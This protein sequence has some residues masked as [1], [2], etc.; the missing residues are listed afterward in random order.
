MALGVTV[1]KNNVRKTAH[2]VNACAGGRFRGMI[3]FIGFC[4]FSFFD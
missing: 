1:R 3:S 4:A 2:S